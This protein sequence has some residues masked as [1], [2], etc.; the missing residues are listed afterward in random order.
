MLVVAKYLIMM[1]H[2]NI[3]KFVYEVLI[4]PKNMLHYSR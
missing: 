1:K 3:I 2:F 4:K